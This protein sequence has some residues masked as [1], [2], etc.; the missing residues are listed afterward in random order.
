MSKRFGI[1]L[2]LS[3]LVLL[4][5]LVWQILRPHEP[6]YGGKHLSSWL[7][8]YAT[9][10]FVR[11]RSA[12]DKEAETAIR[13]IGTNALPVL[14]KLIATKDSRLKQ[15]LMARLPKAWVT[16]IYPRQADEY[17]SLGARGFVALGPIAK[18]VVPALMNLASDP[19][20]RVRYLAIYALGSL[21]SAAQPAIPLLIQRLNDADDGT[22]IDAMQGLVAIH[23]EPELVIPVFVKYVKDPDQGQSM[24]WRAV[25]GLGNFGGQAKQ[26]VP[27]LLPLLRSEDELLREAATNSLW[28]ID[29]EA[30][31]KAGVKVNW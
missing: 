24:R 15:K 3:G 16:W 2:A 18:P 25:Q 6:V 1:A 23:L 31:A 9:N 21:G 27:I 10:H 17:R 12:A 14:L 11:P 7:E 22:R 28:K 29:R 8:Q 5:G 19:D 20:P 13:Q 30:A 4:A 26:A